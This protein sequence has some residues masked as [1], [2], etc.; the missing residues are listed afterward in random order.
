MAYLSWVDHEFSCYLCSCCCFVGGW[1]KEG[2]NKSLKRGFCSSSSHL[3]FVPFKLG[4]TSRF[5]HGEDE[6]LTVYVFE[7][8][9]LLS[10][11]SIQSWL[12]V[13][14]QFKFDFAVGL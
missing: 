5:A 2:K 10:S 13:S 7:S 3:K 4:L 8:C 14:V 9:R 6:N 12:S 11:V 1:K